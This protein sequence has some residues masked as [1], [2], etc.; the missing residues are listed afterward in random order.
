[1]QVLAGSLLKII[2]YEYSMVRL[3]SLGFYVTLPL[4]P[5]STGYMLGFRAFVVH[6]IEG[7]RETRVWF[8]PIAA[9]ASQ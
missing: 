5:C 2:Q 1:M 6:P 4:Q 7:G 9:P 3:S 8:G